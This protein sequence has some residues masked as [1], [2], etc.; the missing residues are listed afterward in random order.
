MTWFAITPGTMGLASLAFRL[1]GRDHMDP[2]HWPGP[3]FVSASPEDVAAFVALADEESGG[4]LKH[5]A[6]VTRSPT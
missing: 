4:L 5:T 1:F 6:S 3:V 2:G